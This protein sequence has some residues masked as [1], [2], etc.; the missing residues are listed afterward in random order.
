[1]AENEMVEK[2]AALLTKRREC[3]CGYCAMIRL[4]TM[5]TMIHSVSVSAEPPVAITLSACARHN[6]VDI[7]AAS[8]RLL[9]HICR[10]I[11]DAGM[12][13]LWGHG[14]EVGVTTVAKDVKRDCQGA[15][16]FV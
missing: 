5:N 3:M 1:M 14:A 11:P 10:S 15:C 12:P 9:M 2:V 16:R 8:A 13:G 7:L 4:N 6:H